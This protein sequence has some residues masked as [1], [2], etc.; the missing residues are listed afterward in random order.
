[1]WLHPLVD[2]SLPPNQIYTSISAKDLLKRA[3]ANPLDLSQKIILI[4]PNYATAGIDKEGEDN[5]PAPAAI[6]YWH[7]N[8]Y[9]VLT[10]GKYHAYLIQHFLMQRLV[11]PIPDVW[12][13]LLAVLLG[14]GTVVVYQNRMPKRLI[15]II[16]LVAGTATYSLFSLELYMSSAAILLPI[17][18]PSVT[19]WIYVLP[20]LVQRKL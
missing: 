9:Q 8:P 6:K 3:T 14:T 12:I 4:V 11:I 20:A 15:G 10:G 7:E 2:Y 18:L 17:V 1:M 16:V 19:F 5:L 13:I